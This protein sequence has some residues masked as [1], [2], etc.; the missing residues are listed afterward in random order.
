M[1]PKPS[2]L[3]KFVTRRITTQFA[4]NRP[5]AARAGT[6]RGFVAEGKHQGLLDD[7]LRAG[8]HQR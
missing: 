4:G 8:E 5:G 1:R 7:L 2:G 3:M 6:L